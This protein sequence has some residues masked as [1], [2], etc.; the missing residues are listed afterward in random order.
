[1]WQNAAAEEL[2]AAKELSRKASEIAEKTLAEARTT[3][4]AELATAKAEAAKSLMAS[5][6]ERKSA[7]ENDAK[8]LIE[9][10]VIFFA[11]CCFS[12]PMSVAVDI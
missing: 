5:E 1:M 2:A 12:A 8:I 4:A 6:D 10:K 11:Q 3:A 9:T 7:A